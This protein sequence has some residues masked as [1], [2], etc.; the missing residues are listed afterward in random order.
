MNQQ[1]FK[2]AIFDEKQA[3]KNKLAKVYDSK[4][5]AKRFFAVLGKIN[6]A[7]FD[8]LP[9]NEQCEIVQQIFGVPELTFNQIARDELVKFKTLANKRKKS[10]DKNG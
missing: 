10:R 1:Q 3:I 4:K 5:L 2:E 9:R 6:F 8:K 7:M